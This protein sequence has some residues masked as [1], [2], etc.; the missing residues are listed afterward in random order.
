LL[1]SFNTKLR[2]VSPQLALHPPGLSSN[3]LLGFFGS[4]IPVSDFSWCIR[5]RIL[6][7]QSGSCH[8]WRNSVTC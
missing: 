2:T 3:R 6:W 8:R 4:T 1:I 5:G 7:P